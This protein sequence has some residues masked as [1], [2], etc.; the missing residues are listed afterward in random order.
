MKRNSRSTTSSEHLARLFLKPLA[1]RHRWLIWLVELFLRPLAFFWRTDP[2][3][4]P[5][6]TDR[7]LVFDPGGLGDMVLLVPFLQ[8]LRHRLPHSRVA[9]LGRPEPAAFLLEQGMIDERIPIEMPWAIRLSGWKRYSPFTSSWLK[10]FREV[11]GLRKD[12]F[13]FAFA[14]GWGGDLRA[15]L[16]VWLSGARRRIGY[17]YAGGAFLL[18]DVVRPDPESPHVAERNLQLLKAIGFPTESSG[19]SL[20]IT[21]ANEASS[22]EFLAQHGIEEGDLLIGVHPGAGAPIREWDEERFAEVARKLVSQFGAKVLWFS[23]P[24]KPKLVPSDL[25]A[26]SIVLPLQQLMAMIS[27][28]QLFI[29]NDSGPM[30]IAAALNVP[31]VAVFGPQRPEWFGPWGEGHRVVI[32]HDIWCRPCADNCIWNE[33]HCLRLISVEQV[34]RE[35]EEAVKKLPRAFAGTE[36]RR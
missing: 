21:P 36:A 17:G 26:I 22:A 19:Q 20:H 6:G 8:N 24:S 2:R 35:V 32:R 12:H 16:V 31:V 23:D 11:L 5:G 18:T 10:F 1:G 3:S 34:M 33:P 15:N 25:D 27:R 13:D 29:C 30:H 4:E 9:L 28:C 14:A 7:I